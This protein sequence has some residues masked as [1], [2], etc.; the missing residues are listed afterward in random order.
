MRMLYL[1]MKVYSWMVGGGFW[2]IEFM[3]PTL[4]LLGIL[5]SGRLHCVLLCSRLCEPE[6]F[7]C[8]VISANEKHGISNSASRNVWSDQTFW[9]TKYF[10]W[11]INYLISD[12]QH[13]WPK[14]P[15]DGDGI[16]KPDGFAGWGCVD[17][18]FPPLKQ[19]IWEKENAILLA[20]LSWPFAGQTTEGTTET[21]TTSELLFNWLPWGSCTLDDISITGP[22]TFTFER[23]MRKK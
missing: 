23:D 20:L 9:N 13:T 12:N 3:A 1:S 6:D 19:P 18:M 10:C 16:R 5:E 14:N 11:C 4:L 21:G 22:E 8:K 2:W 15:S 17:C 7:D